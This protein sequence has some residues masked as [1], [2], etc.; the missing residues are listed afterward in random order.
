MNKCRL[1]I[2]VIEPS[3]IIFEGLSNILI[4]SDI[5]FH[6]YRVDNLE[7]LENIYPIRKFNVV[8]I[9]PTLIQNRLNCFLKL[10]AELQDLFW[11]A[12]IYS[13]F[14][15]SILEIFDDSFYVTDKEDDISH[16]IR[17][18]CCCDLFKRCPKKELTDRETEVL[19]LLT[20][21]FSNKGIAQSLNISIHTVI[22]HRKKIYKKTAVK[23]LPELTIYAMSKKII[24]LNSS[25]SKFRKSS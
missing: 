17:N 5:N 13:F 15:K 7:E 20:K 21:G 14:D 4:K 22:S 23:S 12:V 1:H 8:I 10:K 19:K 11:I 24:S 2:A 9:N 18:N 16:K 25:E 3:N 6:I